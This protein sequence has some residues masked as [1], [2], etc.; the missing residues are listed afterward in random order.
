MPE[1][2]QLYG[3]HVYYVVHICDFG[4]LRVKKRWWC[5][6][7]MYILGFWEVF[8][9][10]RYYNCSSTT[11]TFKGKNKGINHNFAEVVWKFIVR[12]WVTRDIRNKNKKSQTATNGNCNNLKFLPSLALT[13][14][15]IYI[16]SVTIG[17][18]LQNKLFQKLECTLK[19]RKY[20]SLILWKNATNIA[21]LWSPIL[22]SRI[23]SFLV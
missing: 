6:L 8:I 15:R 17:M 23:I 22:W 3:L 10:I 21:R 19:W 13:I 14:C 11:N 1:K 18:I 9:F 2:L 5:N 4:M 16:C 7:G 12:I 20:K